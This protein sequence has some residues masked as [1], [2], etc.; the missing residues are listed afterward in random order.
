MPTVID[1]LVVTLGL[2]ID[3]YKKNLKELGVVD[4]KVGAEVKKNAKE[5]QEAN[6]KTVEGFS[7]IKTEALGLMSALTVAGGLATAWAVTTAKGMTNLQ[8]AAQAM[9]KATKDVAAFQAVIAA[10]GGSAEHAL[11]VLQRFNQVNRMA[12]IGI[13]PA[14]ATSGAYGIIGANFGDDPVA[15]F[16]KFSGFATAHKDQAYGVGQMLGLDDAEIQEALKGR[17]QF[18]REYGAAL[19]RAGIDES[20]YNKAHKLTEQWNDLVQSLKRG[21]QELLTDAN[22]ALSGFLN[23]LNDVTAASPRTAAA[24]VGLVSAFGALKAFGWLAGLAG[25]AGGATAGSAGAAGA[26][27]AAA[28]GISMGGALAL[29][30]GSSFYL[31]EE[32][33]RRGLSPLSGL[34]TAPMQWALHMFGPD[35]KKKGGSASSGAHTAP[36]SAAHTASSGEHP[37]PSSAAHTVSAW[38]TAHGVSAEVASGIVAGIKAEGGQ[39]GVRTKQRDGGYTYGIGQWRGPRRT[40]LFTKY[41]PHPT[42]TQELEFLLSELKGGDR[43][44]PAVLA[45][46]SAAEAALAYLGGFMRPKRGLAGDLARAGRFLGSDL[47]GHARGGTTINIDKIEVNTKS[48]DARGTAREIASQLNNPRALIASANQG[49]V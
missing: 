19:K 48:S 15:I 9:G 14:P 46:R 28:G 7:K 35:S 4:Q 16:R 11:G 43:G 31:E 41:G 45:A 22:P 38:L 5:L 36:N 20:A 32:R 1:A 18:G 12:S 25:G 21:G 40:A 6:K 44:G 39:F 10:N 27:G 13:A 33:R 3:D 49:L 47:S 42:P 8:Q 37:A 30:A 17:G 23:L 29:G 24:I 26:A 2:N 34:V